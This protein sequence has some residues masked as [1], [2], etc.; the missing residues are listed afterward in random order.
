MLLPGAWSGPWA[1]EPIHTRLTRRG[2]R[3]LTVSFSG[4][5]PRGDVDVDAVTLQTHV[6]DTLSTIARHGLTDIV[7]VGHSYSGLVAGMVTDQAPRHIVRTVYVEG[8]LARDGESL[9]D[10]FG[11]EQKALELRDI[12]ANDG[13]W[14]PPSA[15]AIAQEPDLT[16]A[17]VQWLATKL[18]PHPARTISEPVELSSPIADQPSTVIARAHTEPHLEKLQVAHG[19][20]VRHLEAGHW[21]MLSVPDRLADLLVEA[22]VSR[23]A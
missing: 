15:A 2:H 6:D 18:L 16:S 21:P 3:V 9:L 11:A 1:W 13:W 23:R 12:R 10:A 8:F 7:L 5:Q 20:D 19:W 17:H 14:P 22:A 4:L